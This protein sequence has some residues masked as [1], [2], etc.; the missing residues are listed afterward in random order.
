MKATHFLNSEK[1]GMVYSF[2]KIYAAIYKADYEDNLALWEK[3]IY[4]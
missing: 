1:I 4:W 2:G 3:L